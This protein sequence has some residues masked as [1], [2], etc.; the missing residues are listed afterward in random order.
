WLLTL[1]CVGPTRVFQ[2]RAPEPSAALS[3][4]VLGRADYDADVLGLA[5]L[6]RSELQLPV[7]AE[8]TVH[9]STSPQG[10]AAG[11]VQI[12]G[13]PHRRAEEIA[14]SSVGLGQPRRLFVQ[15]GALRTLAPAVRLGV[16]AHELTHL[17]Q[18]EL[19]GGRRGS[20]EQWLRE[21]MAEWVACWVQERLG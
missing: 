14:A 20:S 2:V 17:A 4:V 11:L 16:L 7:P 19:A 1:G 5:A 9:V 6:L 3:E 15:D 10:F 12:G 21:G 18:Y 8:F 13:V